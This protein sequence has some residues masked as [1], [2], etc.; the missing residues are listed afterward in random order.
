MRILPETIVR[1]ADFPGMFAKGKGAVPI[2]AQINEHVINLC[3]GDMREAYT[4]AE[5]FLEMN[6]A[7]DTPTEHVHTAIAAIRHFGRHPIG[8]L[9]LDSFQMPSATE[10]FASFMRRY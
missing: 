10:S 1:M 2:M 5:S 8:D 9:P 4:N 3:G 6:L 7:V